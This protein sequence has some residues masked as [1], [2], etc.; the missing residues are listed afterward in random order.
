[1]RVFDLHCDTASVFYKKNLPFDNN[2]THIRKSTVG[3]IELTQC[4][5]VF[6]DDRKENPRAEERLH[7][8]VDTVFP[9]WNGTNVTPI[10]T[11]E[12][13]G[14]LAT[15]E[16]WISDLAALGCRMVGLT[17]NGVNPLGT[18]AATDDKAPLT[19]MGRDAVR[20]ILARGMAVD[21]SHL[22]AKGTE[23]ILSLTDKP[24]VASHSNARAVTD[25]VR[26]LS[27]EVASEIF[28]RGGLVGLNLCPFFLGSGTVTTDDAVRHAEHFLAL[29]G[30]HGLA[31][32]GDWDGAPLPADMTDFSSVSLL[33]DKFVAA[34]GKTISDRIFYENAHGFFGI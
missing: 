28:R 17:W 11:V 6:F 8:V 21:V 16:S 14:V 9:Q 26:N 25:H 18:G 22:S 27:D 19:E 13:G 3:Q 2:E 23:E 34:F 20:E 7:R 31:L 5:A 10:L 4:F 12:G 32:G 24:I 1:M 33:Y 29:G 30:E 15:R